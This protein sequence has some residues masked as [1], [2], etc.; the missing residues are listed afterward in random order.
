M[1]RFG[2]FFLTFASAA[3]AMAATPPEQPYHLYLHGLLMERSGRPQEAFKDYE[4]LLQD[5]PQSVFLHETMASLALRLGQVDRALKEAQDVVRLSPQKT[6]SHIVLGRVHLARGETKEAQ[7]A[8][9]EALRIDPDSDEALLYAAHLQSTSQ[10]KEAL[11]LYNRFLENNPGSIEARARLAELYQ[12]VG[13]FSNAESAWR[14]V[15]EDDPGNFA[16][17]LALAHMYEIH[18]DTAA[19]LS[20]YEDCRVLDPENP[21]L[22]I[23]LGELYFR[24]GQRTQALAAFTEAARF[25]PKDPSLNFWLALLA[26]EN[27]DWPAA[28]RH[29]DVVAH[30]SPDTGVLLR[31]AFYHSQNDQPRKALAALKNLQKRDPDNP[32]VLYYLATGYEELKENRQ[33]I[34][35]L[36]KCLVLD[37][38]RAEVNF[39]LA[40]NWDALKRFDKAEPYLRET[41]KLNP[42]HA[43]ALNFL[44]YSLADRGQKLD[45]ALALIQKA[46]ALE[47]KNGAFLD[48]LGW[49]YFKLNR[50]PE[51]DTALAQAVTKLDDPVIWE[52]RGDVLLALGKK[53]DAYKAWDESLLLNPLNQTLI[54]KFKDEGQSARLAD[55]PRRQLRLVERNL[56]RLHTLVGVLQVDGKQL[57]RS[58]HAQ[59]VFYYAEPRRFRLEIMGPFFVPQALVVQNAQG[60][61]IAPAEMENFAL[62]NPRAWMGL[63]GD[64]FSGDIVK[65]FGNTRSRVTQRGGLA[66]FTIPAGEIQVDTE[67]SVLTRLSWREKARSY[68]LTFQDYADMDGTWVPAKVDFQ[69]GGS[70]MTFSLD[71]G[72]ARLNSPLDAALF[73]WPPATAQ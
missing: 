38:R 59:G 39:R 71:L 72:R 53:E 40:V 7:I 2:I 6:R 42:D 61:H 64:F 68:Q 17:R 41:L 13:D 5:D 1:K 33:A 3:A 36:E 15:V 45:E 43:V 66:T 67:R 54:K 65:A 46:V 32:D 9:D 11:T 34:R 19:A 27:K 14:K 29:M 28:A 12:Q 58:F 24:A 25:T 55:L 21:T 73:Q 48:S 44:G 22:L 4:K 51:A 31:L 8:F 23:R 30:A 20:A 47:P 60:F 52:H 26:E 57:G 18:R 37:P 56:K 63:L 70:R 62:E 35:W 50:L 10:P 16:A 69:A 49:V